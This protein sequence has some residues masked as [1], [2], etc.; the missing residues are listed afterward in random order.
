MLVSCNRVTKSHAVKHKW[1]RID[2]DG[3]EYE[4]EDEDEDREREREKEQ[5]KRINVSKQC[6]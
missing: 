6:M 4:N 3:I 2:E 1:N 5:N